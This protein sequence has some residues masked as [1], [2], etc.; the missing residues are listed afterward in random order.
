MWSMTAIFSKRF[1]NI[2]MNMM[3]WIGNPRLLFGIVPLLPI[4]ESLKPKDSLSMPNANYGCPE[5]C[6]RW[7]YRDSE[8][9]KGKSI[10]RSLFLVFALSSFFSVWAFNLSFTFRVF[11]PHFNASWICRLFSSLTFVFTFI[12]T[13]KQALVNWKILISQSRSSQRPFHGW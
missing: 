12:S 3:H 13:S 1:A 5:R 9:R 10:A 4:E 2:A 7:E 8:R 6:R 11:F